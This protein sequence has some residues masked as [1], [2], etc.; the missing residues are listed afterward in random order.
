MVWL[1]VPWLLGLIFIAGAGGTISLLGY[2]LATAGLVMLTIAYGMREIPADP[3]HKGIVLRFGR[4]TDT[5]KDEGWRFVMPIVEDLI[6]ADF[7]L[8]SQDAVIEN[9]RSSDNAPMI[10]RARITWL[11][12]RDRPREYLRAGAE[13]GVRKIIDGIAD[14]EIRQYVTHHRWE[15]VQAARDEIEELLRRRIVEEVERAYGVTVKLVSINEA[16]LDPQSDIAKEAAARAQEAL[17]REKSLT[18]I[19]T[20]LRTVERLKEL[21]RERGIEITADENLLRFVMKNDAIREG[22]GEYHEI[23]SSGL[24]KLLAEFLKMILNRQGGSE[25]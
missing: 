16:G 15:E 12:D 13:E 8:K 18:E 23:G 14:S 17:E 1:I 11:P 7:T 21:A 24:E 9:V 10:V 20:Y 19:E 3:P 22:H 4:L 25:S 6:L 5:V 2:A